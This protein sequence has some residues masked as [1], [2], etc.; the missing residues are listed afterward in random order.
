MKKE[1][2]LGLDVYF[3]RDIANVLRAVAVASAPEAERD[4]VARENIS[5]TLCAV[6]LAFGLEPMG[7]RV[8]QGEAP[9]LA[10]LLW[11][12]VNRNG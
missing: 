10:G 11:A 4:P 12:E 1:V 6:G 8:K 9:P 3:R 7:Q 2:T 5:R